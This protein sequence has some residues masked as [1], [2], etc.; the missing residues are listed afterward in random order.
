MALMWSEPMTLE[1]VIICP[2][3]QK[4]YEPELGPR[5][6]NQLI[7]DQFPDAKAYQREQY[8]SGICSDK[9]WTEYLN[10]QDALGTSD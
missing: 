7:Q 2:N 10:V 5:D 1:P 8:L 6:P 9:C 4:A 3:C